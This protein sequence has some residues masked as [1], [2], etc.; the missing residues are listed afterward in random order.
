MNAP[1]GVGGMTISNSSGSNVGGGISSSGGGSTAASTVTTTTAG[2]T[3]IAGG[4]STTNALTGNTITTTSTNNKP[5]LLFVIVGINEPLYEAELNQSISAVAD[6]ITRQ[7]YF[8]L[9]SALDLA[10]KAAW[11]TNHM[12]LKV[13]DKVNQQE[14]S[15]FVTAGNIKFMLLH[16]GKNDDVIKSF[17]NDVYEIYVKLLMNPF[18]QYDA[19]ITSKLF[20]S[21]VRAIGRRCLF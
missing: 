17:F 6:S 11:T 4:A 7:N 12:Y 13:V 5:Q 15:T 1:G 10:D 20:D 2:T 3:A 9:H 21:R 16:N 18:T 19:P 14:V 8:V